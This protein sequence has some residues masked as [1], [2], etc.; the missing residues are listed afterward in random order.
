MRA[1]LPCSLE[2]CVVDNRGVGGS[3]VPKDKAQYSTRHMA[4]DALGVMVR[5]E[6]PHG[7]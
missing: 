5:V 1:V 2:V 3:S 7:T 6:I 4:Q